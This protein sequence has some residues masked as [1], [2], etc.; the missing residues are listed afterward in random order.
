[1]RANAATAPAKL[2]PA[3]TDDAAPV[4]VVMLPEGMG[5]RVPLGRAAPEA[6][7]MGAAGTTAE[8]LTTATVVG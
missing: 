2:R 1:M 3:W 7:P 6:V 8:L 4:K 5:A